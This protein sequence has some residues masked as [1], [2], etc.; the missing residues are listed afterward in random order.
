[1]CPKGRSN[2]CCP[3]LVCTQ[4]LDKH[5][6]NMFRFGGAGGH[7]LKLF[8][9]LQEKIRQEGQRRA[10]GTL[11]KACQSQCIPLEEC[12]L[13]RLKLKKAS[14]KKNKKRSKIW[15]ETKRLVNNI[16]L[17][18]NNPIFRSVT[19]RVKR[20]AAG[21]APPPA[22]NQISDFTLDSYTNALKLNISSFVMILNT[23]KF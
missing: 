10:K 9:W 3:W 14:C 2:I 18:L 5:I 4:I 13:V 19:P 7:Y 23:K 21:R 6:F 17:K 15:R 16:S 22:Q 8:L 12:P 20:S 11:G 1:M